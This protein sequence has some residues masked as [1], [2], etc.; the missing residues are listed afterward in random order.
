M[1]STGVIRK[2]DELEKVYGLD[3]DSMYQKI[4]NYLK[5]K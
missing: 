2:I 3:L 4:S 5:N 1:K